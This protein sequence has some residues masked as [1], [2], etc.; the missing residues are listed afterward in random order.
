MLLTRGVNNTI[1]CTTSNPH[2]KNKW[3]HVKKLTFI[4]HF[5]SPFDFNQLLFTIFHLF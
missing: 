4:I 2:L 1:E 5:P 3:L